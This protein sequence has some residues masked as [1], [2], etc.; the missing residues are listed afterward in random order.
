MGIQ[1]Y[2]QALNLKISQ[3]P[4]SALISNRKYRGMILDQLVQNLTSLSSDN[5]NV[6]QAVGRSENPGREGEGGGV[7]MWGVWQYG[8]WSFQMG[9]TKLERFL[10]KNQHTQRKFLNFENPTDGEPHQLAKIR[11]F[12]VDYFDLLCKKIE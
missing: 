1:F 7:V 10:P 2:V 11:V 8:L 3:S 5:W 6:I 9:S 12:K 4:L